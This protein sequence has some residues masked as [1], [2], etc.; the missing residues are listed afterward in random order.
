MIIN[1]IVLILLGCAYSYVVFLGFLLLGSFSEDV[2][3]GVNL[4][5]FFS[6]VIIQIVIVLNKKKGL[7][8]RLLYQFISFLIYVGLFYLIY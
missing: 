5:I 6:F 8:I 2:S 4:F 3:E 7:L 1:F